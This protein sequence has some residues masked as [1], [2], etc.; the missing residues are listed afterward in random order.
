MPPTKRQSPAPA[1]PPV[2]NSTATPDPAVVLGATTPGTE[3]TPR[4]L[5]DEVANPA[6]LPE[7]TDHGHAG[8]GPEPTPAATQVEPTPTDAAQV[9][10]PTPEPPGSPTARLIQYLRAHHPGE[11]GRVTPTGPE[12]PA[13]TAVRLL[14][15]LGARGLAP[16]CP[17]AYC[18]YPVGHTGQHGMIHA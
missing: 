17:E 16:R 5:V 18:N 9:L 13:D 6:G 8:D 15:A 2:D 3:P 14:T 11:V 1:A 7:G 12:H 4:T 10:Q